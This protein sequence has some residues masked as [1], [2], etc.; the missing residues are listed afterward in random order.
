[1]NEIVYTWNFNPLE[2]VYNEETLSNVV[3]TVHWQYTATF[4][5]A[6]VEF[7]DR[8]IGVVGLETPT[9]ESFVPFESLTKETVEGWVIAKLGEET[10]TAMS[11]NLSASINNQ[12]FPVKGVLSPPWI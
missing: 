2:V 1:M 12:L 6:S 8:N 11:T 3:S 5:S 10:I 7:Y 9:V 4:T